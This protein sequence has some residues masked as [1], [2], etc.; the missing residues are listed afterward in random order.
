MDKEEIVKLMKQRSLNKLWNKPVC[1]TET[2][3]C[4]WSVAWSFID[5]I[6]QNAYFCPSRG[7]SP[8]QIFHFFFW[9]QKCL[10]MSL[11]KFIK[12]SVTE[13]FSIL[14][15]HVNSFV[16]RKICRQIFYLFFSVQFFVFKMRILII[17]SIAMI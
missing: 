7:H 1:W 16:I 11:F 5:F 2:D 12:Y 9:N 17:W 14:F 13:K 10:F 15:F 8:C 3:G 6:C 4:V